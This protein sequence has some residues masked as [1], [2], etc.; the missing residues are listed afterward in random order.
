LSIVTEYHDAARARQAEE[1]FQRVVQRKEVPDEIPAVTFDASIV[2]AYEIVSTCAS[3]SK[4][5]ARRLLSQGGVKFDGEK[6]SDPAQEIQLGPDE[7]TI[8][9]GKRKFFRIRSTSRN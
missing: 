3:V 6:V 8:Q 5:E 2:P 9:V 7:K 1:H 4:A